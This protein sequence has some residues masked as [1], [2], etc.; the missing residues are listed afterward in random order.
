MW[1]KTKHHFI[2]DYF[3]DIFIG[4]TA[5]FVVLIVSFPKSIIIW[6]IA[7]LFLLLSFVY[8]CWYWNQ[9]AHK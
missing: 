5:G 7:I 2:E 6:N 9:E 3:K 8:Y 1:R 4:I